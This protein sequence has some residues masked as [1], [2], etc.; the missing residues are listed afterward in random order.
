MTSY[1]IKRS[2][3]NKTTSTPAMVIS[4]A[5]STYDTYGTATT[6]KDTRLIYQTPRHWTLH[7]LEAVNLQ[8]ETDVALDRIVDAKYIPSDFDSG[9]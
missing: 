5:N 2:R 4:D 1:I 6:P 9:E 8:H 7:H 3:A